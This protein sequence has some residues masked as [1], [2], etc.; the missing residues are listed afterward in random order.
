MTHTQRFIEHIRNLIAK[1]DFAT[2]I[3][4]LSALLKDSPCL[5]EAVQQ[6]ARYNN[7]MQ[8]IRLGIVDFQSANIT[9]NQIR[10]STLELLSEIEEQTA[11]DK[12]ILAEVEKASISIVNSKNTVVNSTISAG[13]NVTIGDTNIQTES[14]T[15]RKLR[16]FLYA[17]VPILA[18]A[19]AFFYIK[20]QKLQEPLNLTVAVEDATPNPNIPLTKS[21]VTLTYGDKTE[22]QT[23][24]K[25]AVFKGIPPN[26]RDKN[27]LLKVEAEGFVPVTKDLVF[28]EN[29]VKIPL[30]RDDRYATVSGNIMDE[31]GHPVAAAQVQ[32]QDISVLSN[33]A[34]N[35]TLPIPFDKQRKTQRVKVI[36]QGF[37]I[38]DFE[39]NVIKGET[40]NIIFKK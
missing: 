21:T 33:A 25:E 6:S 2:A 28:S 20:Y 29:L 23:I 32:I 9:L 8:Q 1:D 5:N 13:G 17:F 27:G 22:N 15:S 19:A 16:L 37:K 39:T 11:Q 35:F 14:G 24:E 36:K 4:Q 26:F 38:W 10:Y 12:G 30:S 31:A 3:E 7:V 34:G 18:M 40:L